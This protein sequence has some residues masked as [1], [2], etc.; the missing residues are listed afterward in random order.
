MSAETINVIVAIVLGAH[1]AI[2]LVH[3]AFGFVDNRRTARILRDVKAILEKTP[4]CV[5]R[6][7]RI[8]ERTGTEELRVEQDR[9]RHE[10]L[11]REALDRRDAA[12]RLLER[13]VA[14]ARAALRDIGACASGPGP[15]DPSAWL[16]HVAELAGKALGEGDIY[17][18]VYGRV[19][20]PE[21]PE[22]VARAYRE[23]GA[24]EVHL[25]PP[26]PAELGAARAPSRD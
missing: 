1:V 23:A 11:Q 15:A 24:D 22:E 18:L 20:P 12:I 21:T 8:E 3:Y 14:E 19:Q 6:L 2:E 26:A 13:D 17:S 25:L 9:A 10:A 4:P 7:K 16:D 5:A